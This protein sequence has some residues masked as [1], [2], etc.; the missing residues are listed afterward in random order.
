MED[1]ASAAVEEPIDL[2][3]TDPPYNV[4]IDGHVAGLGSIRHRE[5]AFA[6]GEMSRAEFT[7]CAMRLSLQPEV[8]HGLPQSTWPALFRRQRCLW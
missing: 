7:A 6:S 4:P 3:V 5:F 1:I 2:I 8:S